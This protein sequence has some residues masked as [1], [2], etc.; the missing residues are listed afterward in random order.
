MPTILDHD[1]HEGFVLG[2]DVVPLLGD[3]RGVVITANAGGT[4]TIIRL[5]M[6]DAKE[7]AKA[8]MLSLA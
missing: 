2:V 6:D 5:S 4:T 7:L 8:L 1:C 3:R